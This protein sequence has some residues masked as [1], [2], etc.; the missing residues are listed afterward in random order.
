MTSKGLQ[1]LLYIV[2]TANKWKWLLGSMFKEQLGYVM[3]IFLQV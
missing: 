3:G 1:Q 2:L